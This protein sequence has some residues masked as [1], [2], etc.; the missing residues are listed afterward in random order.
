MRPACGWACR[1]A[2]SGPSWRPSLAE[3]AEQVLERLAAAGATLIESD[4]PDVHALSARCSAIAAYEQG[5]A[6]TQYLRE[7]GDAHDCEAIFAGLASP[8]V[9][10]LLGPRRRGFD[11][12][13]YRE[14]LTEA[15][16]ALQQLYRSY[17]ADHRLD[18]IIFP[19]TQI[20]APR[21]IELDQVTVAGR[22]LS[23]LLASTRNANPAA[24]AGSPALS[25]PA[26]LTGDGL[27]VGIELDAAEGGDR[28]LLAIGALLA[29]I[30]PP[31]PPPKMAQGD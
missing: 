8:D 17:F 14:A 18:A 28:R 2:L 3:V 13:S 5:P 15:R 7:V 16:P 10:H 30:L 23:T 20:A 11:E 27:P 26:G 21:L 12:S 6:L 25:V 29:D 24:I 19:T 9:Q 22:T 4:L 1:A 31:V